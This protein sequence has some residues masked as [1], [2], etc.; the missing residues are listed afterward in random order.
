MQE[1]AQEEEDNW[2]QA[3]AVEAPASLLSARAK[4]VGFKAVS[5]LSEAACLRFYLTVGA[6]LTVTKAKQREIVSRT[7]ST[8]D[9][10][11][12]QMEVRCLL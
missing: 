12:K 8:W 6:E 1:A 2:K 7:V 9:D 5:R 3:M 11:M 10:R 4:A